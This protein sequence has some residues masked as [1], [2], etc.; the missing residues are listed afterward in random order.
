[1]EINPFHQ[2]EKW[3]NVVKETETQL[4]PNMMALSTMG[5]DGYPDSRHVLLK[6]VKDGHFVFFTNYNSEKGHQI[7]KNNRVSLLFFWPSKTWAVRIQGDCD[8]LPDDENDAYFKC[9]P[10]GNQASSILS[11]QSEI[12]EEDKEKFVGLPLPRTKRSLS[13]PP[14]LRKAR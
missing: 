6:E 10:F 9:R 14:R 11:H 2:F 4:E 3:F 8:K 1:M 7:A 5:L 13:W 12:M